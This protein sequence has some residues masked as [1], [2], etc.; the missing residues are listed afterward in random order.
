MPV[1]L[2]K[3]PVS[4]I[5]VVIK[6]SRKLLV[7]G[8]LPTLNS[9]EKNRGTVNLANVVRKPH[10]FRIDTITKPA[11]YCY[12]LFSELYKRVQQLKNLSHRKIDHHEDRIIIAYFEQDH[13]LPKYKLTLKES[14]GFYI[15]IHVR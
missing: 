6:K 11:K 4:L 3:S 14:L 1:S 8:T 7:K 15:Q 10:I 5:D 12:T 9:P 13:V 2:V